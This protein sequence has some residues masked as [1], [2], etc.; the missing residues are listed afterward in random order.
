MVMFTAGVK[1]EK[2]KTEPEF[3]GIVLRFWCCQQSGKQSLEAAS[4][5]WRR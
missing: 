4:S 2:R 5:G 3:I 1:K